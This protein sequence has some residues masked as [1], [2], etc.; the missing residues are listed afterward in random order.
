M[1]RKVL[2]V[3]A[4]V[5]LWTGLAST[6]HAT[7]KFKVATFA[8]ANSP[9]GQ[10]WKKWADDVSHDTGGE[11]ELE[12]LWNGQAGEES[13]M[14]QKIRSGQLDGAG[15]T[16]LGLAQTGVTDVLLFNAPGVFSTW[17]QLDQV[18]NALRDDLEKEFESKG[19]TILGWA[20]AGASKTM[21]ID[22]A[23]HRPS[24]LQGKGLFFIGGDPIQPKIY[25]AV[26]G[27]TPRVMT[28]AEILPSLSNG[29]INVLTVPPLVAE[30][31]QW[32]SRITHICNQT[33]GY[34]TGATIVSAA[35]LQAL[36]PKLRDPLTKRA[37]E[38]ADRVNHRIR[39]LDAQSFA[40]LK[41]TKTTYDLTDA[42]RKEWA[43]VF[44]KVNQQLRGS[45]F[46]PALFDR[47]MQLVGT[48][49]DSVASH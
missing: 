7:T 23:L 6:A 20:D 16:A 18:R 38:M 11:L 5:A 39:G 10:E 26:S 48:S 28:I 33:V 45:V 32:A 44:K 29:S 24:D 49:G 34:A 22:F 4:L 21:T 15:L 46:T 43:D 9:W 8:P 27:V 13:L 31:L 3:L 25:S 37:S 19:F 2:I 47:A 36:P 41:S 12:F 35:R 42:E 17:N 30:Q 1:F 14:V 40:R